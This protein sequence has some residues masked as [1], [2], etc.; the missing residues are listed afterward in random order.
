[1]IDENKLIEDLT[2]QKYSF[3]I[4]APKSHEK[5]IREMAYKQHESV[6]KCINNQPKVQPIVR[7]TEEIINEMYF[8]ATGDKDNSKIRN[9]YDNSTTETLY[10]CVSIWLTER[11]KI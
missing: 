1:M 4:N 9:L 8:L 3:D 10:Q 2:N 6:L 11:K 7:S 5:T